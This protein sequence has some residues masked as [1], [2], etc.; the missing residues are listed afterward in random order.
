[1]LALL[2][3]SLT[4][5]A[6]GGVGWL[7]YAIPPDPPRYHGL[8]HAVVL[9]GN[10]AGDIAPEEQTAAD[11]LDRGL[12][13]MV[14]GTDVV[15]HRFDLRQ[16]AIIVGTT[17]ALH[18]AHLSRHLH[19]WSEKPLPEEGFRIVHLRRG[20]REWYVL[21]GGSPRAEL[22]AAFRFAALVAEDQQLPQELIET[23]RLAL[24]ALDMGPTASLLPLLEAAQP[25]STPEGMAT[26][27]GFAR[28]LAS[29]G[30]NTV[31]ADA[32][33]AEA[34]RLAELL[35][36]YGIRLQPRMSTQANQPVQNVSGTAM[37]VSESASLGDLRT[38]LA[39]ANT[40]ARS[41][42]GAPVLLEGALGSRPCRSPAAAAGRA[43]LRPAL[44]RS[45]GRGAAGIAG[46]G[47][48]TRLPR[49]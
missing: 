7:R 10:A 14:A 15:L 38:V 21:Q 45:A 48:R 17:E 31:I 32:D 25:G 35:H 37:R 39:Q 23:P 16:D 43:Q 12:G 3:A 40:Q 9:L 20:I 19:G 13:H 44:C 24:R 30:L 5:A 4:A 1:M 6:Q 42:P 11:E 36:P 46:P 2:L 27:S 47:R 34:A 41:D 28:L 29:V 33:A 22:W 26:R 8:P 49:A 18:R